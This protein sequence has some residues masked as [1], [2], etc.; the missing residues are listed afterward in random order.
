VRVLI[1]KEKK[2]YLLFLCSSTVHMYWILHF[3][4]IFY[5][6]TACT[7]VFF[8]PII[9]LQATPHNVFH[10]A[11]VRDALAFVAAVAASKYLV[12]APPL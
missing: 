3:F 9:F 12:S 2:N 8:A 11:I 4:T 7:F 10:S 1:Y 5:K 6:F